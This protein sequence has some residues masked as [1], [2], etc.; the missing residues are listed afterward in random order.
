[1]KNLN[2]HPTQTLH[3]KLSES[4]YASV[5][6]GEQNVIHRPD[7]KFWRNKLSYPSY[8]LVRLTVDKHPDKKMHKPFCGVK[9]NELAGNEISYA[10]K[11]G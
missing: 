2:P 4:E 8:N 9:K 6:S 1:M 10:I 11:I 7:D 3:I 5:E